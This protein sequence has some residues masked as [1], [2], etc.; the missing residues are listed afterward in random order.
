MFKMPTA[1]AALFVAGLLG[2]A[3]SSSGAKSSVGD[4]AVGG[5]AGTT[6][7]ENTGGGSGGTT[8]GYF[9]SQ[10]G[11]TSS[12]PQCT[13]ML[14]CAPEDQQIDGL[15]PT[16]REC[17]SLYPFCFNSAT[18]CLL[19]EGAHCNDLACNPGDIETT[20]NDEGCFDYPNTCYVKQLCLQ[21][22]VCRYRQDAGVEASVPDVGTNGPNQD[23]GT[24]GQA[25]ATDSPF[26]QGGMCGAIPECN[27]GDQQVGSTPGSEY[28][29]VSDCPAERECYSLGDNCDSILCVVPLGVHCDDP[30]SC[31]PGDTPTVSN[32]S[33]VGHP[34]PCYENK[35]CT[36]SILCRYG[37]DAGVDASVPD[38]GVDASAPDAGVD[39]E[40]TDG[41]MD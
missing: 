40:M 14:P 41:E 15:C 18:L 8:A 2:L 5:Q 35:L 39:R 21:S 19:P 10:G 38:S 4:G 37:I 25:D 23:S 17:Y 3:C 22:V 33:C 12:S 20:W 29:D 34:S 16:E 24:G 30:L 6:S 32:D 13:S 36:R 7:S 28:A 9:P 1:V 26:S 27:P 31:N 11:Q